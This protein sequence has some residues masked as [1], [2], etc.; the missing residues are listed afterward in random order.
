MTTR[1][2]TK[3]VVFSGPFVLNEADGS[4]DRVVTRSRQRTSRWISGCRSS[5]PRWHPQH[6]LRID[7]ALANLAV[8]GLQQKGFGFSRSSPLLGHPSEVPLH[9]SGND[10]ELSH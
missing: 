8:E 2:T 4:G 10:P 5:S 1:V 9:R 6:E 3:T 7:R